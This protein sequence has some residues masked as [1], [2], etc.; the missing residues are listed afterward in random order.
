MGNRGAVPAGGD[1]R[2]EG[3]GELVADGRERRL[4]ERD[5]DHPSAPVAAFVQRGDDRRAPPSA[6]CRWSMSDVAERTPGRSALAGHADDS[7]GGLHQRVVAGLCPRVGRRG[8]TRRSS[9]DE[10]RVA[11]AQRRPR[12]GRA[13]PPFPAAGSG[14]TTSAPSASRSTPRGPRR[15][16]SRARASASTAFAEKNIALPPSRTAVPRAGFVAVCWVLDLDDV[17][18]E[19]AE[20]PGSGAGERARQ[21]ENANAGERGRRSR[22]IFSFASLRGCGKCS[23]RS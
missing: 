1:P 17:G 9:S 20:D 16:R 19:R 7:G 2:V 4:V 8:R 14:R 23:S 6:R 3:A 15:P 22:F 13:A 10:S 5:L 21:V 12:R 11:G 18:A